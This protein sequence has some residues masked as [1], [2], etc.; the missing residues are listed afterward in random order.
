MSLIKKILGSAVLGLS[1]ATSSFAGEPASNPEETY[2][3]VFQDEENKIRTPQERKDFAK[4]L[5]AESQKDE[6][7][8]LE[9]CLEDHA[10][11]NLRKINDKEAYEIIIQI[12]QD[13]L[14]D[15]PKEKDKYLNLIIQDATKLAEVLPWNERDAK[16]KAY[17]FIGD[18]YLALGEVHERKGE[19]DKAVLAFEKAVSTFRYQ[20]SKNEKANESSKRVDENRNFLSRAA[21][22]KQSDALYKK[23]IEDFEREGNEKFT[24]NGLRDSYVRTL[25]EDISQKNPK[26]LVDRI[27]ECV[28]EDELETPGVMLAARVKITKGGIDYWDALEAYGQKAK[29]VMAEKGKAPEFNLEKTLQLARKFDELAKKEPRRYSRAELMKNAHG[30]Y[31][32]VG[33][34]AQEGSLAS[35]EARKMVVS[36]EEELKKYGDTELKLAIGPEIPAGAVLYMTFDE[37]T[38]VTG[39]GIDE[40]TKAIINEGRGKKWFVKDLSKKGNHG[41][42]N[43]EFAGDT[44]TGKPII[45]NRPEDVPAK[46]DLALVVGPSGKQGDYAMYFAGKKGYVEVKDEDSLDLKKFEIDVNFLLKNNNGRLIAVLNKGDSQRRNYTIY[47]VYETKICNGFFEYN[48]GENA[49]CEGAIL[50]LNDWYSLKYDFD[51]KTQNLHINS[52][53]FSKT[54]GNVKICINTDPLTLGLSCDKSFLEGLID[55]ISIKSF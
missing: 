28:V 24:P 51:G 29:Q 23:L 12:H 7:K 14:K 10:I 40:R 53:K 18:A 31:T 49:L 47:A 2:K 44:Q 52:G 21:E 4:K 26:N 46:Y 36:L 30:L 17:E 27:L 25:V 38:I 6:N 13:D 39:D 35:L 19:F 3:R 54:P 45:Y 9:E 55:K 32:A 15:F 43:G 11:D 50:N 33:K 41:V 8:A 34:N 5:F 22:L 48:Q 1:L 37:G 42:I 20:C 16:L